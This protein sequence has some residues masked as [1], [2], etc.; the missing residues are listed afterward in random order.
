MKTKLKKSVQNANSRLNS[1]QVMKIYN[2]EI[3]II[4]NVN[5]KV[6]SYSLDH[7]D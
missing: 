7:N 1:R 5:K 2:L 4:H 6:P 3:E